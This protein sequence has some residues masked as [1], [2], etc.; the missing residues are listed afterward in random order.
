MNLK[1]SRLMRVGLALVI[2]AAV[3]AG[4]ILALPRLVDKGLRSATKRTPYQLSYS[5]K[6]FSWP[7][8]ILLDEVRLRQRTSGQIVATIPK[9][10]I[11]LALDSK[12]DSPRLLIR[13]DAQT[14][15]IKTNGEAAWPKDHTKRFVKNVLKNFRRVGI[16]WEFGRVVLEGRTGQRME[17]EAL[18]GVAFARGLDEFQITTGGAVTNTEGPVVELEGPFSCRLEILRYKDRTV[19]E[20]LWDGK[21]LRIERSGQVLKE[22][23]D[24]WQVKIRAPWLITFSIGDTSPRTVMEPENPKLQAIWEEEWPFRVLAQ[25][26]PD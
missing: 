9:L 14:A 6:K 8:R 4:S 5:Q 19:V 15:T 2:L 24:V 16:G 3:G 11:G 12:P 23:G 22:A 25:R 17:L 26:K 18:N 10:S 21:G 1:G 7:P 20:Q 13:I